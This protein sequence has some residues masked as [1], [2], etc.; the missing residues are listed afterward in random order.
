MII[1]HVAD[2]VPE[3]LT[4]QS[5]K[6]TAARLIAEL[7]VDR[8]VAKLGVRAGPCRTA[9]TPLPGAP[10]QPVRDLI[11]AAQRTDGSS[12]EPEVLEH[13]VRTYGSDYSEVLR[14]YRDVPGWN[15]RVCPDAPV[16]GAQAVR[17]VREEMA[18]CLDDVLW[19]RTELG[20]RGLV[21]PEVRARTLDLL[22]AEFGSRRAE[23]GAL[24]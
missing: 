8:I 20:A 15:A 24:A 7:A 21:T 13:L 2:G 16:I 5:G 11:A 3:A 9:R 23:L 19:R 14:A 6:L 12:V 10:A 1:D 17:A 18:Q 4:L 22:R